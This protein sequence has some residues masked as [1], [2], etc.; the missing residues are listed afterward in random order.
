[1]NLSLKSKDFQWSWRKGGWVEAGEPG[2]CYKPHVLSEQ[3]AVPAWAEWGLEGCPG[4]LSAL[5]QVPTLVSRGLTK[6][7]CHR[8]GIQ[9]LENGSRGSEL[10]GRN[11]RL[12]QHH[13]LRPEHLLQV[14]TSALP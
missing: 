6:V 14:R 9:F 10:P 2:P 8:S 4:P 3:A 13:A 12:R 5:L 7:S 1:M 11:L